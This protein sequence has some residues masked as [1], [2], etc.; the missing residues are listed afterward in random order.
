MPVWNRWS[1]ALTAISCGEDDPFLTHLGE[2]YFLR[3]YEISNLDLLSADVI[4]LFFSLLECTTDPGEVKGKCSQFSVGE[5]Y[6]QFSQTL[7]SIYFR[8]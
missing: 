2:C 7:I 8:V 4:G 5:L 6:R 3:I 1:R